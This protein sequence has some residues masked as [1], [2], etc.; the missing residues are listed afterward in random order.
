MHDGDGPGVR[1]P[2][3]GAPSARRAL[4]DISTTSLYDGIKRGLITPGIRIAARRVAWPAHEIDV[5]NAARIAGKS[6]DE[7]RKLVAQLEASRAGARIALINEVASSD[8][9]DD[10]RVKELV[11]REDTS[12]RRLYDGG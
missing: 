6:D 12:T 1:I 5:I 9:P 8:I 4:G 3:L 10:Q 7:I 11:S 2:L